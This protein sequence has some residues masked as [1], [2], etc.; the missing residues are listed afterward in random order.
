MPGSSLQLLEYD[1]YLAL[2]LLYS[3]TWYSYEN[4]IPGHYQ[5][6]RHDSGI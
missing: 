3:W 2:I 6:T 4:Q 1:M 5:F